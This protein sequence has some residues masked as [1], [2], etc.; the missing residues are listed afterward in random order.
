M[1][2]V[3]FAAVRGMRSALVAVIA[4]VATGAGLV[5]AN[6]YTMSQGTGTTFA[7][8]LISAVN[9]AQMIICDASTGT[10]ACAGVNGSGQLAVAGP[11][12][13]AGTFATQ[14]TGATNNIN[15]IAGTVSLPTGASTSAL[16][17]TGN[18]ALTTINTTLGSPFQAGGS[19]GNT[20]FTA[21]A[22]TN[23]NTSALALETG[24]NLAQIVT[25]FGAPGATACTTDTA[26]CNLNQQMQRNNQR[27]TTINTT[28]GT[29]M[30][31][32]GGSVQLAAGTNLAG[33]VGIDQTTV[34]TTNGVSLAQIGATTVSTGTGAVGTGSQRV[35][36]GAD[37]AVLAGSALGL[38]T[39][40]PLFVAGGSPNSTTMQSA[41]VANGNGT[42]LTVSNYGAA[43]V[44]VNCSVAC[45]GGTTVNFEGTDSTGTFFSIAAYPVAGGA[46]V[47]TATTTGQFLVPVTGLTSVR[48]RISAYSAGTITVTGT[49][50]F[51][52]FPAV[53]T[54]TGGTSATDAANFT[55]G[56]SSGTPA[57]GQ[58]TSGGATACVTGHECTVG[59]T[60]GRAFL[61]DLSSQAGTAITSVPS[62]YGTAPT[63]N[64]IGVNAFVTNTNAN[65]SA[66]SANSS[67]VVIASDQA[68]V[69][70]K[71]ASAS[72]ASGAVASGAI[73]SGAIAS[74]AVASGAVSSG[75]FA[76][77]SIGSGA[78]ASGAI[79]SGAFAAGSFVNATAGDPCMFQA[80]TNV[81]ISTATGT[82]ALVAAVSAKKIYVCSLTLIANAAV[83]VSLSEGSGATCG[84]S[85][86]AGVIGV[87]TN[88]TA[89]NGLSL[90]ANGG[91][92]LGN[93]GGTVA[94]TATANNTL[95]LFQS[96]TVQIAGNM[97]YVQQ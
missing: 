77:G 52:T 49:S 39:G 62:S 34:G 27:L 61:T 21:N 65:G 60:A 17:T 12:T 51:G 83:A 74:G 3:V 79:A 92:T 25:D 10:T 2:K 84:T 96:G 33:K 64:V 88:G 13:N 1:K 32:T 38:T 67:P 36:V 8:A 80:K 94:Q 40:S 63:G 66:T 45:S 4:I 28:L 24:G 93:G 48:A 42:V 72:I 44:N 86:Q 91:L 20:A 7:S 89:A 11:V 76:A 73:A 75:A 87:A 57:M 6:N 47:T 35:A 81:P 69:A 22:G 71:A 46:S 50:F 30:Q 56:T 9:Y 43:L 26:S 18:T 78:I 90:A 41:A 14:L 23:L 31:Q 16:Q 29:P 59:I 5:V 54:A 82:V 53:S 37:S 95:C 58:F 70:I 68:A 97:T 85:N 19:I 15:N 55:A